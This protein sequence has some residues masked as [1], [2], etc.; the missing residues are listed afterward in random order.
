VHDEAPTAELTDWPQIL[1]LYGVL[2]EIAPGP[3]VTLSR[4]VAGA[5]V[6]GARAGPGRP[7]PALS[8]TT[9]G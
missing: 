8:T 2:A 9:S 5:M 3:L 1:A 7:S 6:Y 4:A